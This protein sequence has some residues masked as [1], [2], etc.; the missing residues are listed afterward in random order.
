MHGRVRDQCNCLVDPAAD[1][2]NLFPLMPSTCTDWQ[3]VHLD[4]RQ[5][6]RHGFV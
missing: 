4:A 6:E 1:D 2:R 3:P 5:E